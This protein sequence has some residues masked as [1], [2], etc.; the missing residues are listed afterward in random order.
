MV[1]MDVLTSPRGSSWEVG[2]ME[3]LKNDSHRGHVILVHPSTVQKEGALGQGHMSSLSS[4]YIYSH[5]GGQCVQLTSLHTFTQCHS[6]IN[7]PA[8]MPYTPIILLIIIR[9][10]SGNFPSW[11]G[12]DLQRRYWRERLTTPEVNKELIKETY[13][14]KQ[15][16]GQ[17]LASGTPGSLTWK[18][19][20][21]FYTEV[22]KS[23]FTV[24]S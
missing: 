19:L 11:T 23:N 16:L 5:C 21:G 6:I 7:F 18:G 1:T 15:D 4:K 24:V 13:R 8:L 3:A 10:L 14:Q 17:Q 9:F 2:T 12:I 20:G 22:G